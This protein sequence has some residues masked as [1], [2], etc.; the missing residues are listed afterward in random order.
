MELVVVV[1]VVAV[2]SVLLQ[3]AVDQ[4]SSLERLLGHKKDVHQS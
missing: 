3:L 1:V 4:D 2:E